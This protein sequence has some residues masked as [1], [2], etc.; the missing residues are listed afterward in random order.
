MELMPEAVI[1]DH[2]SKTFETRSG[3]FTALDD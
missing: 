2:V 1:F 3:P